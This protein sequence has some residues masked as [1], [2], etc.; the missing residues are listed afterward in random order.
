MEANE[1]KDILETIAKR[2]IDDGSVAFNSAEIEYED[3]LRST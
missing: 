3:A 1:P 2:T